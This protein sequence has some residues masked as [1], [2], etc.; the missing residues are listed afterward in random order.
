MPATLI[1]VSMKASSTISDS[2]LTKA[3]WWT[4]LSSQ[5]PTWEKPSK[6]YIRARPY[7]RNIQ[8]NW[9][10]TYHQQS[11]I[12]RCSKPSTTAPAYS[13]CLWFSRQKSHWSL[14]RVDSIWLPVK[15][16]ANCLHYPA[17]ALSTSSP[18]T[19]VA[20]SPSTRTA[21]LMSVSIWRPSSTVS[22]LKDVPNT[23]TPSKGLTICLLTLNR[24]SAVWASPFPSP[25][26]G[27]IWVLGKV[28]TSANTALTEVQGNWS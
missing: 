3:R 5:V 9:T 21:T 22:Y 13:N 1:S 7:P 27:S 11:D 20:D 23:N 16:Y 18:S 26:G 8:N 10:S 19:P 4:S 14:C 28:S 2:T 15:S 12:R 25:T 24:F 17:Q 6:M